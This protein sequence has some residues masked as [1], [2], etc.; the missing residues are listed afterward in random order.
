EAYVALDRE[1]GAC[2]LQMT[3]SVKSYWILPDFALVG[4]YLH[5]APQG[6]QGYESPVIGMA[7]ARAKVASSVVGDTTDRPPATTDDRLNLTDQV[8]FVRKCLFDGEGG[9]LIKSKVDSCVLG[10]LAPEPGSSRRSS[11]KPAESQR[12]R[13]QEFA[14][15]LVGLCYCVVKRELEEKATIEAK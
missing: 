12:L 15:D 4:N 1:S 5:F 2:D 8:E 14:E 9:S 10:V 13:V 11:L 6:L 7:K 3:R